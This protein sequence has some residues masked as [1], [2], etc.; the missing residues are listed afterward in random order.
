M[1][2]YTPPLY[3]AP[4]KSVRTPIRSRLPSISSQTYIPSLTLP[5][6]P[7]SPANEPLMQ[8]SVLS[9]TFTFPSFSAVKLIDS[10]QSRLSLASDSESEADDETLDRDWEVDMPEFDGVF[11]MELGN[12]RSQQPAPAGP[13]PWRVHPERVYSSLRAQIQAIDAD[14]NEFCVI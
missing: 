12:D 8:Q 3:L 13:R 9:A 14:D 2:T 11:E 1:N 4:R 10:H 7:P 6:P 5:S